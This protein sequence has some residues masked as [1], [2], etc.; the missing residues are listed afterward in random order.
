M[1]LTFNF[2]ALAIF[3]AIDKQLA[4]GNSGHNIFLSLTVLTLVLG[5][6]VCLFN[7]N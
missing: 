7:T 2:F 6:A 5:D 3:T 4:L 1:H